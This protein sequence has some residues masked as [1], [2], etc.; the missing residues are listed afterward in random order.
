[1]HKIPNTWVFWPKIF[2]VYVQANASMES[3]QRKEVLKDLD[4]YANELNDEEQ[5]VRAEE[6]K[7]IQNN[8]QWSKSLNNH[9]LQSTTDRDARVSV[10]PGKARRLN[11]L[12]QVSV[13]TANHVITHIQ[14]DFADKKDTQCLPSLLDNTINNLNE[15]DLQVTEILADGNY[16]SSEALRALELKN[17]EGYIPNFGQYKSSRKGF[18]Y[19][20]E[21]DCYICSEGKVL[22]YKSIKESHGNGNK[23]KQYRSKAKDCSA[24]PLKTKCIGKSS[25]KTIAVT[26]DKE[27]FEKMEHRLQT[28][29]AKRLKKLRSSTVEPVLGTL[30]NFLGMRRV[31]TKG[32]G[33]ADKCMTMA[34][35]AYNLK[36]LLKWEDKKRQVV[37]KAL[38]LNIQSV[39]LMLLGL[40]Y[41]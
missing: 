35:I 3:L 36:K 32:I 33:K 41:E 7:E 26:V 14:S 15:N 25:F 2:S 18:E 31:Y 8:N 13:D 29:K 19:A 38:L 6:K 10:K 23:M 27:L 4:N 24:C 12:A 34:A 37:A 20:K 17:I 5:T 9:T 30:V 40:M 28:S 21:K 1:M 16:S 11:Y 39:F 22:E